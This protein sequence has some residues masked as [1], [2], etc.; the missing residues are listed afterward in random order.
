MEHTEFTENQLNTFPKEAIVALYMKLQGDFE[1]IR[2]QNAELMKKAD[3]LQE[4]LDVLV[5]QK[6]GRKTEKNLT[7]GQLSLT[8][9]IPASSTKRR[10][11]L[12][13]VFRKSRRPKKSSRTN[14]RSRW[15]N[16]RQT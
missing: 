1:A 6:Y 13:A 3:R 8:S 5:Q 14:G 7:D 10:S 16:G 4:T 15:E 11:R 9:N 2:S 12:R